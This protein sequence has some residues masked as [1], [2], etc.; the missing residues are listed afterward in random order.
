MANNPN[1]GGGGTPKDRILQGEGVACQSVRSCEGPH[2]RQSKISFACKFSDMV[3]VYLTI[4]LGKLFTC[5]PVD[6]HAL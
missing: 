4:M 1:G 5:M 3:N 6:V 2:T